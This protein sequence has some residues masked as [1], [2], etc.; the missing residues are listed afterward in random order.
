M[1]RTA[2]GIDL[3]TVDVFAA[4]VGRKGV[5]IV[6]NGVSERRTPALVSFTDRRR[7]LGPDA[8]A[9]I[10]SNCRNSCRNLKHLL[11]VEP[12]SLVTEGER[13]WS[14]CPLGAAPDGDVGY[15]VSYCGEQRCFSAKVCLAMLL[16][17]VVATCKAWT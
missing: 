5:D 3:G 14:L 17:S 10:K 16:T 12:D 15:E 1:R 6:Q 4:N 11:G 2:V 13:F 7:L 8:Q 9:Q